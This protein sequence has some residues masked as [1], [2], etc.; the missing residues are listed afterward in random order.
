MSTVYTVYFEHDAKLG[1]QVRPSTM[2]PSDL[3]T[4][5]DLKKECSNM[6]VG[7]MSQLYKQWTT[8]TGPTVLTFT[9]LMEFVGCDLYSLRS[10]GY[11]PDYNRISLCRNFLVPNFRPLR[12]RLNL[13][14]PML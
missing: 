14:H 8:T 13:R 9:L 5:R 11:T 4:G 6:P 1:V 12:S 3:R 10:C 2:D 7:T